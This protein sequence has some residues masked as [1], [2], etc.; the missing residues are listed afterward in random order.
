MNRC[1]LFK[2]LNISQKWAGGRGE[3]AVGE[4]KGQ[5]QSENCAGNCSIKKQ[6]RTTLRLSSLSL[7]ACYL[8]EAFSNTERSACFPSLHI[9][10]AG[11]FLFSLSPCFSLNNISS[12]SATIKQTVSKE[13]GV[14]QLETI[15]LPSL[16]K[17]ILC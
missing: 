4:E 13:R 5:K 11:S 14:C 10:T 2:G 9:F 16:P 15:P 7:L 1:N 12:L 17:V 3:N 6:T 8:Y